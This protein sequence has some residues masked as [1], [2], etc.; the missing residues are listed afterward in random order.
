MGDTALFVSGFF[1]DSLQRKLADVTYY[2]AMGGRAYARLSQ[3]TAS[4][5]APAVFDELSGRFGEFADVLWEVSEASRIQN[6]SHSI[7]QL[8]ERWLQTG[9]PRSAQLLA[10]Q[11]ITPMAGE[12]GRH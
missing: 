1:A 7:V 12:G 8:Y 5:F 10:S 3:E 11:G 4:S 9:S 2:R 6:S